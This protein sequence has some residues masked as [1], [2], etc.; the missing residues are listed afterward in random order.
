MWEKLARPAA[1]SGFLGFLER[2]SVH[3]VA[4]A[5]RFRPIRKHMTQMRLTGIA[6]G[7][8]SL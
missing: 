6:D 8:D 5:A 2:H 7:L 3:A 1:S 4:Q